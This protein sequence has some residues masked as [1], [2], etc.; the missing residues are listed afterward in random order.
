MSRMYEMPNS[1]RTDIQYKST[2]AGAVLLIIT[3]LPYVY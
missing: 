2:L 1:S 3:T